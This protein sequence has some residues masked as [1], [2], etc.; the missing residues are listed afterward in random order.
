MVSRFSRSPCKVALQGRHHCGVAD[1]W[2]C[3]WHS[4]HA[5]DDDG[6]VPLPARTDVAR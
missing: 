5:S 1:R 4:M 3:P 6:L 2:L